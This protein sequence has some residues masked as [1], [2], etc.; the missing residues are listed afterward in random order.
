M[1]S[2][3]LEVTIQPK[4]KTLGDE[5]FAALSAKIVAAA[6]KAGGVLRG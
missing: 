3:A 1:K 4:D 2:L 5:D 6:A